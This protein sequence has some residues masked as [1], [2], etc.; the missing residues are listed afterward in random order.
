MKNPREM[1]NRELKAEFLKWYIE[2]GKD[3]R[4][5]EPIK[6]AQDLYEEA[7]LRVQDFADSLGV[8]VRVLRP[9]EEE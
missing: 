8:K 3:S 1:T 6:N 4:A 5:I 2:I 9:S 7:K